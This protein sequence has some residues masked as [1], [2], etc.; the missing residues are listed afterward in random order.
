MCC[1]PSTPN[2]STKEASVLLDRRSDGDGGM[3]D[4][5]V[6]L[7]AAYQAVEDTLPVTLSAV[8]A[9]LNGIRGAT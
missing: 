9:K 2:G 5:T 7:R 3:Q 6:G 1:S 8:Y 4:S